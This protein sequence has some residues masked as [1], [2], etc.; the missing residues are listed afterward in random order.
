[1]IIF[2][3][4]DF[5]Y[6]GW[7]KELNL[8]GFETSANKRSY[9][10]APF[11]IA[12]HIFKGRKIKAF[13]FRYLNDRRS[14]IKTLFNGCADL[15]IILLCKILK[16]KIFW[17]AHNVDKESNTYHKY[18]SLFRRRIINRYAN[19]IMVTDPLLIPYAKDS[20]LSEEKLD[21]ISFGPPPKK[22]W[23]EKNR[24]LLQQIQ[25]F[26]DRLKTMSGKTNVLLGLC[27]SSSL[28]KFY[29]FLY[30]PSFVLNYSSKESCVGL[31]LIGKLPKGEQFDRARVLLQEN[32]NI[33]YIEENFPV[34]EEELATEIDFIYKSVADISLPYTVYVA[35]KIGKPI[36]THDIGFLS[37][38]ITEYGLGQVVPITFG[39]SSSD[40]IHF[41][42]SWNPEI[43]KKFLSQR[44]WKHGAEKIISALNL[45]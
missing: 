43:T 19:K 8:L 35:A 32:E 39:G 24:I 22:E 3:N 26:R 14:F 45:N 25:K 21:W 7:A 12:R 41:L 36:I 20:G 33:L 11:E 9:V 10:F 18:T 42:Q 30:A 31:V 34:N 2:P 29:H 17:I 13:V 28:P 16:I 1:M 37:K 4:N 27:V 5:K 15:I 40:I 23:D 44:S 6:R 38:M